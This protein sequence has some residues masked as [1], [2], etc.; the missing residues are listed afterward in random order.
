[1]IFRG[2]LHYSNLQVL[3]SHLDGSWK[4]VLLVARRSSGDPELQVISV[5]SMVYVRNGLHKGR[6]EYFIVMLKS[7]WILPTPAEFTLVSER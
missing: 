7:I 6:G 5:Y 2:T 3:L 1:M 4:S